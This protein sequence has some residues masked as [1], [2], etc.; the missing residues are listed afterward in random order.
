MSTTT[1]LQQRPSDTARWDPFEEFQSLQQELASALQ[2][3]TRSGIG[4]EFTPTA[5]IEETGDAYLV[6]IEVPG[7]KK[8]DVQVELSGR[9][10]VVSGERKEREREG[11]LRRRTRLVGRFRY[12][13]VLPSQVDEKGVSASLDNGVLT[14]RVPKAM[15]E[16]P[17]KISVH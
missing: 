16:R 5:D 17:R 15:A 11:V 10:L 4:G 1:A 3:F 9:R 14:V 7:V 13:V 12:E 2:A 8:D 6:E